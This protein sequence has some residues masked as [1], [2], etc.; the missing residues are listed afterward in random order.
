MVARI[1]DRSIHDHIGHRRVRSQ[2]APGTSRRRAVRAPSGS[3][4]VHLSGG[5]LFAGSTAP[6]S[7]R[8]EAAERERVTPMFIS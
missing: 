7:T 1:S 3:H 5:Q 2:Q 4:A 8:A 6:A